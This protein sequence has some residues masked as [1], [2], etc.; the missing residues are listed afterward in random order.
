[1]VMVVT[2]REP[3]WTK[4]A[5]QVYGALKAY[6]KKLPRTAWRDVVSWAAQYVKSGGSFD[7]THF[8]PAEIDPYAVKDSLMLLYPP[9]QHLDFSDIIRERIAAG[10]PLDVLAQ[11]TL[12]MYRR[13]RITRRE[14]LKARRALRKAGFD[15]SEID[16]KR[17][18]RVLR[19]VA[20]SKDAFD[21]KKHSEALA[22]FFS[23]D[24]PQTAGR[25]RAPRPVRQA[26]GTKRGRRRGELLA[27]PL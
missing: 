13:G 4:L 11:E 3:R 19:R 8:N 26:E 22:A 1:M 12:R 5:R 15:W 10:E 7:I 6:Y 14:Y 20:R 16:R 2:R 17:R 21:V 24:A 9:R 18:R 25:K 27:V 23:L